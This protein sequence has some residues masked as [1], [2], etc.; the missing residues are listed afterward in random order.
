MA[1]K[2]NKS[3]STSGI[4]SSRGGSEEKRGDWAKKCIKWLAIAVPASTVHPLNN[5]KVS[6]QK[7][8]VNVCFYY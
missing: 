6:I 8:N 1:S 5:P 3:E 2:I 4:R 7:N